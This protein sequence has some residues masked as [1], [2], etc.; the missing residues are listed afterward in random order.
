MRRIPRQIRR[1]GSSVDGPPHANAIATLAGPQTWASPAAWR[2]A[3]VA[4]GRR[5][6]VCGEPPADNLNSVTRSLVSVRVAAS[7][8]ESKQ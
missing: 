3:K 1:N 7:P 5:G 6:V 4:T 2:R 8:V